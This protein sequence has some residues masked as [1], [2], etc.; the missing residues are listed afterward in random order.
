MTN[1]GAYS[2]AIMASTDYQVPNKSIIIINDVMMG[3]NSNNDTI[4]AQKTQ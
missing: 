4:K 3:R 1:I 2:T